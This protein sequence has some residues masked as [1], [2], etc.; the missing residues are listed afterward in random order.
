MTL[1][2]RPWEK[3][4]IYS[5]EVGEAKPKGKKNCN[6]IAVKGHRTLNS[7]ISFSKQSALKIEGNKVNLD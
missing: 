7:I 2:S 1:A 6:L 3:D 4:K 5:K